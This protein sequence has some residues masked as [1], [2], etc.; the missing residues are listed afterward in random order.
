MMV[1]TLFAAA[2][3]AAFA[4]PVYAQGSSSSASSSGGGSSASSSSDP[5]PM[6]RQL[7]RNQ[8]GSLS[9]EEAKGSPHEKAFTELDKNGDGKLSA[10]EHAAAHRSAAATG[11]SS[12]SATNRPATPSA[13]SGGTN[14]KP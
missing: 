8:D 4:L 3:G 14:P 6:F 5:A 1:K 10:E 11:G 2:I 9:R 13:P 12:A 7:D